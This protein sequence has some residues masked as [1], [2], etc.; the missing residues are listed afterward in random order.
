MSIKK[1]NNL[2][3]VAWF[4]VCRFLTV[5]MICFLQNNA[6]YADDLALSN[7]EFSSLTGSQLQVQLEMNGAMVE[8]KI[9]MT[10][11]PSRIALDFEN[12]KS[13]LAKK[14][15]PINQ[16]PVG[17][18]YV[19]E[20][21]GRTR[22]VVNLVQKVPYETKIDGNKLFL[23]LKPNAGG[24]P[25]SAV[26]NKPESFQ[27]IRPAKDSAIS[28]FLPEQTIK[29]I[30]FR[31]GPNGEGRLLVGLSATNTVVDTKQSGGK[32]LVNFKNTHVPDALIKN[33]DVTDFATPVQKIDINTHGDGV[34]I[35]VTPTK[36]SYDY[37][38]YQTDNLLTIE[39][40]PLT[41]AEKEELKK[42][43]FPYTGEKL[44]LN[45]QDIE[46]RSVLQ[47][48]ADFTELNIIAADSVAGNVTLRLNDVPWDQALELIL[49]SK[50]LDKRQN[51]N[52]VMVAPVAEIMKIEQE[53]LDSQKI[54]EQLDPLKT[55]YIQINY[56]KAS[57]ICNVLMGIGNSNLGGSSSGAGT[58][59]SG[60]SSGSSG[61]GSGGCGGSSSGGGSSFQQQQQT[62][63]GQSGSTGNTLRLLSPRGVAIIDARTNTIIIKDTSKALEEVRKMV[64][65]LDI[66][67]R[68]VMIETRIVIANTSF[69]RQLGA[70]FGVATQAND[71]RQASGKSPGLS[72]LGYFMNGAAAAATGGMSTLSMTLAAG[73]NHLL[74]LEIQAK[75]TNGELENIANPRVMTT[76]RVK[77][78]ILQ[79]VQ[80]PYTSQ[81]A[82]TINTNFKDAVLQLDVTPQIT[83]GGSVVMD[84]VINDDSQGDII[85]TGG[86]QSVA[87]NKKG[88]MAKVQVEDGETVVLGGVYES[89]RNNQN[90]TVPWFGELP[91][92]GWLFRN[93]NRTES[94]QELLIFVTPKVVKNVVNIK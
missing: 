9:F 71:A 94:N 21:S 73:A 53:A 91:G 86:T 27:P 44:S 69:A 45:F 72:E 90:Y 3:S 62:T 75:Q 13:N 60:S 8:P 41:P 35:A 77:A 24:A 67:I 65:L 79:G 57:E 10:D 46:I 74:D 15:F 83:P 84:L 31:R 11:N 64:K 70:T 40:R 78:T 25:V 92:L 66:P 23:V 30:D 61:S 19:V 29:T 28:K 16:G 33:L 4:T 87:I 7:L 1:I 47:I 81:T 88:L 36:D 34:N 63:G 93:N 12:V 14:S 39:F 76:D 58:S 18:V 55:E 59:S 32:I 22:V 38:S 54:F 26:A 37:S 17:T 68:Q 85:T 89:A 2:P 42:E 20:A 43:K 5:L 52:V 51:G 56:A 50:G 6:A 48:L 49:K 82:N 80:I